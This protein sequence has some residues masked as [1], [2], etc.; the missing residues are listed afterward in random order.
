MCSRARKRAQLCAVA[1]QW[2]LFVLHVSGHVSELR[3]SSD[4]SSRVNFSRCKRFSS[5]SYFLIGFLS[6]LID[7]HLNQV[8]ISVDTEKAFDK[9]ST[10]KFDKNDSDLSCAADAC[11]AH[12]SLCLMFT[13][14]QT[15]LRRRHARLIKHVP[16]KPAAF[17]GQLANVQMLFS[18]SSRWWGCWLSEDASGRRD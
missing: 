18:Q 4:M 3:A 13:P 9:T 17:H 11:P 8:I 6:L 1:V 2:R 15:R 7:K 5:F 12:S 10:P 14:G 16:S